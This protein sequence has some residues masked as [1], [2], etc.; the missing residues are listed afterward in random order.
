[1]TL[2]ILHMLSM[3]LV[4]GVAVACFV[5]AVRREMWY[6]PEII[7]FFSIIGG[8]LSLTRDLFT[9]INGAPL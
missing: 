6:F 2:K 3:L 4:L 1:M 7:F 9:W 5:Q 8:G